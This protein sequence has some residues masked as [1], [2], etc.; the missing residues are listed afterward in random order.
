MSTLTSLS[1]NKGNTRFAP[2]VKPRINRAPTDAAKQSNDVVKPTAPQRSSDKSQ[3]A[4]T[5]SSGRIAKFPV[6]VA[7]PQDTNTPIIPPIVP[8]IKSSPG[9]PA[10]A[11][12]PIPTVQKPTSHA[13]SIPSISASAVAPTVGAAPVTSVPKPKPLP[14]PKISVRSKIDKARAAASLGKRKAVNEDNQTEDKPTDNLPMSETSR[15]RESVTTTTSQEAS[16]TFETPVAP[17][18]KDAAPARRTRKVVEKPAEASTAPATKEATPVRRVLRAKGKEK[19]V[20]I[21]TPEETTPKLAFKGQDRAVRAGTRI[22]ITRSR[23]S[24]GKEKAVDPMS[25]AVRAADGWTPINAKA[26][27]SAIT[28][29][30]GKATSAKAKPTATKAKATAAKAKTTTKSTEKAKAETATKEKAAK[31]AAKKATTKRT[32]NRKKTKTSEEGESSTATAKKARKRLAGG[33]P[34]R[35]RPIVPLKKRKLPV[36]RKPKSPPLTT[37]DDFEGDPLS[38]DILDRPMS[39]FIK[40]DKQGIVSRMFKEFEEARLKKRKRDEQMNATAS[41][42]KSNPVE[43]DASVPIKKQKLEEETASA[44][45]DNIVVQESSYAPQLQMV[46]GQMMLDTDSLAIKRSAM[47]APM[48][49]EAMEIVEET[50]MTRLVNSQ[51]YGKK[52]R[53][54]RWTDEET[55][56]FYNAI[57]Q[58]GTDFE[59]ISRLFPDRNRRQIKLKFTREERVAPAKVTEYLIRKSKPVDLEHYIGVTGR[60]FDDEMKNMDIDFNNM[61]PEKMENEAKAEP[62]AVATT[63][64]VLDARV[65]DTEPEEEVL[66]FIDE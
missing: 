53:S 59:M 48:D 22:P 27:K 62:S 16:N 1:V 6:K 9:P 42:S 11:V 64:R 47:A 25:R 49:T 26:P 30:P 61:V 56:Q 5:F 12:S 15:Q 4:Q 58:W 14:M 24:K 39:D 37:L 13:P 41:T 18:T 31:S 23:E 51:T 65:P 21:A 55:A 28:A 57:A 33:V 44:S 43:S 40:D 8:A 45:V 32:V 19:E 52:S 46:N 38:E 60:T 10:V 3:D 50:S 35:G 2:K 20:E 66:G 34:K 29:K 36:I 54:Q 63:S 7:T 17:K